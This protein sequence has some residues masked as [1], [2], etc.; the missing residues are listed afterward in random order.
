MVANNVDAFKHNFDWEQ[1][2]SHETVRYVTGASNR[3]TVKKKGRCRD[4]EK[5]KKNPD[6]IDS[7]KNLK[8]QK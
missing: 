7:H 5:K 1:R 3:K 4:F 2:K 8:H 6:K